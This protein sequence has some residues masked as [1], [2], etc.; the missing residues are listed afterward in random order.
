MLGLAVKAA[1]LLAAARF[2][3]ALGRP[4]S[5]PRASTSHTTLNYATKSGAIAR[6][7]IHRL[8]D[9]TGKTPKRGIYQ[10]RD[11]ADPR[12][13]LNSRTAHQASCCNNFQRI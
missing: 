6:Q 4:V 11:S 1:P 3:Y 13:R 5:V 2:R 10:S 12:I 8:S 9:L 7:Y